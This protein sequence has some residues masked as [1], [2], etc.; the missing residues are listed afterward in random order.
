MRHT[1]T[2]RVTRG[3]AAGFSLAELLVVFTLFLMTFGIT[4][5]LGGWS[6]RTQELDHAKETLRNDLLMA[7]KDAI[8]GS[9]DMSWGVRFTT[10]T[11]TRF[12]GATYATRNATFDAVSDFGSHITIAGPQEIVFQRPS[13]NPSVTGTITLTDGNKTVTS[14]I[15]QY[16]GIDFP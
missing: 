9:Y 10:S 1:R 6:Q 2:H 16:G 5:A 4:A 8:S 11:I 15:N 14:T 13:G 7:R 3:N 12:Q